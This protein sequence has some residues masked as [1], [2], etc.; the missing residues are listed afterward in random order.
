MTTLW[1]AQMLDRAVESAPNYHMKKI[2]KEVE[3]EMKNDWKLHNNEY[4]HRRMTE[5]LMELFADPDFDDIVPLLRHRQEIAE[6]I[7]KLLIGEWKSTL[8]RK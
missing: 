6:T 3:K 8:S 7:K 2:E 4:K 5:L 1:E